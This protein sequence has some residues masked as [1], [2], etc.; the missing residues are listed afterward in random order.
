M[1]QDSISADLVVAGCAHHS[2]VHS[3]AAG[4]QNPWAEQEH[5]DHAGQLLWRGHMNDICIRIW[6]VNTEL[7]RQ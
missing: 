4:T 5:E 7:R 2:D 3:A 6:A 1:L